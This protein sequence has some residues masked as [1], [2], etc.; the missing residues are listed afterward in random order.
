MQIVGFDLEDT[1]DELQGEC[2]GLEWT[3]NLKELVTFRIV[4]Y[5]NGFDLMNEWLKK[6]ICLEVNEG[7]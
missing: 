3:R 4:V 5:Y 6:K 2:Y 7:I 1:T